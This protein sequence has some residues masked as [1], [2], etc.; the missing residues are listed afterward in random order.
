MRLRLDYYDHNET[1]AK[2]L[3]VDGTV[4]RTLRSEKGGEWVLFQPDAPVIYEGIRYEHFLLRSRW[5]GSEI[6]GAKPTSVFVLLVRHEHEVL[7]GFD[8]RS[9]EHVAWGMTQVLQS[10]R[11]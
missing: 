11:N 4:V 3:P 10:A 5:L 6:G 1:F 2:I 9:F 7:D 8:V